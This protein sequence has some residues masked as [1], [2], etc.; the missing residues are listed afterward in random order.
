MAGI[1]KFYC[2]VCGSG[3][4]LRTGK[5]SGMQFLGCVRYFS[6]GCT[7][8]RDLDGQVFGTD[9]EYPSSLGP[10]GETMF[11]IGRSEGMS[12]EEAQELAEKWE[13]DEEND[14]YRDR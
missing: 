7:G 2:P 13:H 9:G 11:D 10:E 1:S 8:K 6:D 5:K 14:P 4:E 12:F 3:M